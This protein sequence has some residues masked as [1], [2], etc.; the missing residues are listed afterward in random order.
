MAEKPT[1]KQSSGKLLSQSNDE[2]DTLKQR[3]AEL[4]Y[5]AQ[6][7][8]LAMNEANYKIALL[9]ELQAI[10]MSL[11]DLK[12]TIIK[13]SSNESSSE[14]SEEV[15]EEDDDNEDDE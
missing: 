10:R 3:N 13:V 6:M 12:E 15:S 14:P 8:N 2:M 9:Q 5:H 1:L 7:T 4:E 11:A